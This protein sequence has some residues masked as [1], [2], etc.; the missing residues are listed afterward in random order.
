[1]SA[2]AQE[3]ATKAAGM[4]SSFCSQMGWSDLEHLVAKF[5]GEDTDQVVPATLCQVPMGWK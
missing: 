2:P 1:M 3:N 5:Q 4:V